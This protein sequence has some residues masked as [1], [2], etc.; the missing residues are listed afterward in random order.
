MNLIAL[1]D[2]TDHGKIPDGV[3]VRRATG[4]E[5]VDLRHAVLRQGLPRT[6]AIFSADCVS[7]SGH[8]GAFLDGETLCCATFHL[9]HWEDAAAFQLR[10]MATHPAYRGRGLGAAVL[11]LAERTMTAEQN[12][13]Q[14]WCNARE[15]AVPFY[16]SMGWKVVS[17]RFEIPTAGPHY[18][19]AKRVG[20]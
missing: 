20:G 13:L 9:N 14:L 18:K 6:D 12:V 7:S 10:G 11:T 2:Q 19:M 15:P 8:F 16:Q 1:N 4:A 17:E 5:M 3:T